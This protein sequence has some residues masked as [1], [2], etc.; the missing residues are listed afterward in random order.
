[1]SLFDSAVRVNPLSRPVSP[2]SGKGEVEIEEG[3]VLNHQQKQRL[4][5][6]G[7][8][9]RK[10][11]RNGGLELEGFRIAITSLRRELTSRQPDL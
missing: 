10:A 9:T 2:F 7:E 5:F 8:M 1:M 11:L 6:I 3:F 4:K